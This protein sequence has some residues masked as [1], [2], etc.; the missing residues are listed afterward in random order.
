MKK[1]TTIVLL[2]VCLFATNFNITFG[3]TTYEFLSTTTDGVNFR[4]GPSTQNSILATLPKNT[5]LLKLG[6]AKDTNNTLWYKVYDFNTNKTGFIAGYLLTSSGITYTTEDANFFAKVNVEYLNVRAGPGTEFNLI[7]R[8]PQN[9]KI[10]VVKVIKRS[11]GEVWYQF[12]DNK[13]YYFVASWHT[14]KVKEETKP[15]NNQ[16]N[17]QT[18]NQNNTNQ[19]NTTKTNIKIASTSTDFVNLRVGPSTD[20]EKIDLVNKGDQITIVGFAKNHNGELWLQAIYKNKIGFTIAQYFKFDSTSVNLDLSSIGLTSKT[21]DN[22]NLREGPSTTFKVMQTVP[23]DTELSIVGVAINKDNENWYEVQYGNS[24]YWL[25]SDTISIVKKEKGII[26]NVVWEISE[27]GIDIKI[28][29]KNLTKPT[30]ENLRDPIRIN[31]TYKNTDL[32][33]SPQ[34]SELPVFPITRYTTNANNGSSSVTIYL[35]TDIPYSLEEKSEGQILHITLPK[36]NEELVEI[37]GK[38]IFTRIQKVDNIT[39]LNLGDLLTG[40]NVKLDNNKIDFYGSSI[41]IDPSNITII[42]N[43]A[44]IPLQK[45]EEV[46]PVSLT[47]TQNTIFIDPILK[48]VSK[49]N[50][51]ITLTFTFPARATK[52]IINENTFIIF[53]AVSKVN[54]NFKYEERNGLNEPK[55]Y[56]PITKDSSVEVKDNVVVIEDKKETTGT[57]SGKIIVIDPGH[58]SYS[59][60]YLD[61]GAIGYSGSK[62]AY[63][64]LSIALKLKDLL[65]KNGAKVILT[66]TTVD[67]PNNPG[68]QGRA[69]IANSS[70]GDI[71]ISIHLNSSTNKDAKGTETY[72]WYDSSKALAQAIQNALVTNLNTIDRGIKKDYLYVVR[73]V[74]TMPAILTEIGFI[75]NPQ[76]ESLL[77]D[78][79]FQIRVANALLEGIT[80]YFNGK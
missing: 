23:K 16:N 78:E 72:Y 50:N 1:F 35:L 6:T 15:S 67:D 64:V 80:R 36:V 56:V 14:E 73:E 77:K 63:I 19:S 37:G 30:I 5:L 58:G 45:I 2:I 53:N 62:E 44:Y 20:Y 60:P 26:T 48:E 40:F 55:I 68:L 3:A 75:S 47:I 9:T 24:Y 13:N 66:H 41:T 18:N 57:L 46:F 4:S 39:Y 76:E 27:K 33:N 52:T 8:L 11:D 31:L 21:T 51:A 29:G 74:T 32:L 10:N 28:L 34:Q 22:T 17:T 38:I 59:G 71:F 61:V 79:N 42:E 43:D 7:K 25:R 54:T 69:Q 12:E 49:N 70:S 65:E